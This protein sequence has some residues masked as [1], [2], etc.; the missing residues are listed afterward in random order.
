[1]D[2]SSK[3]NDVYER[4]TNEIIEAI[5]AGTPEFRMPWHRSGTAS[6]PRNAATGSY[7]RGVNTVALWAASRVHGYI[8]PYWASY[9][10]WADLGAQV[11]RGER[12]SIVVFYK[13]SDRHD[14]NDAGEDVTTPRAVLRYSAVFNAAQVANWTI[15][16][17][18]QPDRTERITNAEKFV[19]ALG[20][21]IVYGGTI[22][23]YSPR[24]D[25]IVMPPR[26]A[27]HGTD[28]C[29][30]TEAFYSTLFHEHVHWSGHESRLKRDLSSKFG[31]SGYAM[32]E[33]VAE[34]G[35]AF[36][37]AELGIAVHA[38]KDHAAYVSNWLIVLREQKS[39]I[40]TASSA[41]ATACRY[42]AESSQ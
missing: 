30:P 31:T 28:T 35:A 29:T 10:Q 39:A 22:A 16:E 36:L 4:V 40:F 21:E 33:L 7:Y 38:R 14:R 12:S 25:R 5:E 17:P 19:D 11:R 23:A 27:F 24:L 3:R 15:P 32:E 1:M 37:S 13:R 34:L 9:R 20:A 41:A 2:G 26:H 8:F 18:E 6:M 42:L